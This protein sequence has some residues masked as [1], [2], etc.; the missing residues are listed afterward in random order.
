MLTIYKIAYPQ[1]CSTLLI[2]CR[3]LFLSCLK[4][5]QKSLHTLPAGVRNTSKPSFAEIVSKDLDKIVK[6]AVVDTFNKQ[7]NDDRNKL[8]VAIYRMPEDGRDYSD[9]ADMLVYL[10]FESRVIACERIGR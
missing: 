3:R 7:R 6:S 9:G 5:P 1:T 8:Y 2:S 10:R 4:K